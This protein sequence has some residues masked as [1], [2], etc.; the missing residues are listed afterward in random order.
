M[1]SNFNLPVFICRIVTLI[2]AFTVHEF[3]HAF[4]ADQFG[5]P[6]PRNAGRLTLNPLAHLDVF[7]SLLLVVAGFGWAKPVPINPFLL[8]LRSRW[9]EMWVSLAGPLSNLVMAVVAAI[10]L[11][12]NIFPAQAN[13]STILPSPYLFLA[14]FLIINVTLAIFNLIPISPLDGEKVLTP[15]LPPSFAN[16]MNRIRPYGPLVLLLVIAVLPNFG[17]DIISWI[18]GPIMH[19]ILTVLVG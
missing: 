18:M 3:S 19:V 9:A 6:T 15:F 14:E 17:I 12:L 11:R 10:P 2:L 16:F 7:G 1:L 8:N 13:A 5:D 4:V